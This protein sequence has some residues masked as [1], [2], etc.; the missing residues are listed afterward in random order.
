MTD[1]E[2]K[3]EFTEKT[4][5]KILAEFK[6]NRFEADPS[7]KH[8]D[9]RGNWNLK[10]AEDKS[11]DIWFNWDPD[12]DFKEYPNNVHPWHPDPSYRHHHWSELEFD[13]KEPGPPWDRSYIQSD[14]DIWPDQWTNN[15]WRQWDI[16]KHTL[17]DREMYDKYPDMCEEYVPEEE[18]E[19][20]KQKMLYALEKGF[21]T[22]EI[23]G[24]NPNSKLDEPEHLTGSD[25]TFNQNPDTVKMYTLT[26]R[27]DVIP[28][29]S[30]N[31]KNDCYGTD[32][33]I[34]AFDKTS[35]TWHRFNIRRLHNVWDTRFYKFNTEQHWLIKKLANWTAKLTWKVNPAIP[36]KPKEVPDDNLRY[37][38]VTLKPDIIPKDFEQL[39]KVAHEDR[40]DGQVKVN[41]WDMTN[42]QVLTIR[43]DQIHDLTVDPRHSQSPPPE[44]SE[45]H[46]D[47]QKWLEKQKNK[48]DS[49]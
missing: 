40:W 15:W 8:K 5:S 33:H 25:L 2:K 22:Y 43:M 27:D 30:N 16:D 24:I 36:S 23:G 6:N 32:P 13:P 35:D 12:H 38:E 26:L 17:L 41:L 37:C 48:N 29:S 31:P 34:Y 28:D 47:H 45:D 1:S 20:Y 18:V 49:A 3:I 11:G 14:N 39:T 46:P 4:G 19:E 21:I 9:E 42:E 7:L 10:R 44:A